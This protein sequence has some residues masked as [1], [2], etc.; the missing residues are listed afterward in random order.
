MILERKETTVAYRCPECGSVIMSRVGMFALSAD[1]LKLK[2]PCG[3]SELTVVYT[4]DKKIRLTVPCFVCPH[5][6]QFTVS[7]AVFFGEDMFRI[8]CAVSGLDM[9]FAGKQSEVADACNGVIEELRTVIGDK[10]L[11]DLFRTRG[12]EFMTDPQVLDI[13][14]YVVR[15]LCDEGQV[16][17]HCPDGEGDIDVEIG[18]VSVT[19]TCRKCG[20]MAVIPADSLS[21][22]NDFLGAESLD[23]H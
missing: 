15:D 1:M 2:C 7:P 5:P 17:C 21:R 12:E 14:N 16:H 20:A 19:V 23:L 13:V 11:E 3:G 22:A 6:H 10:G 4:R 9:C 18:D 8:P